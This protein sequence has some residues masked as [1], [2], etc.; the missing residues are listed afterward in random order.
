MRTTKFFGI[1]IA[2]AACVLALLLAVEAG[3][4]SVVW[5]KGKPPHRREY[6][7]E[8]GYAMLQDRDGDI[9]KSD[10]LGQYVDCTLR[11]KRLGGNRDLQ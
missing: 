7:T 6:R 1:G 2:L 4:I 9:I 8:Y 10:S 11:W 3:F 5:A